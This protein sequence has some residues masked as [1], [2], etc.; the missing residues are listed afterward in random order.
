MISPARGH[1]DVFV[2]QQGELQ[3]ASGDE[4]LEDHVV[5]ELEGGK[6]RVPQRR[7][8]GRLGDS[9]GGSEVGGLH[10]EG[11]PQRFERPL[12]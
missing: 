2:A 5:V 4:L 6:D 10:E 1:A 12:P 9:D 3:L 7:G 8:I 11:Q